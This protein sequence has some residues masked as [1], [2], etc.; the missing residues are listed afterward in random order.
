MRFPDADW[1]VA[2]AC[3]DGTADTLRLGE[4]V[5]DLY[6]ADSFTRA[7]GWDAQRGEQDAPAENKPRP[8]ALTEAQLAEYVGMYF[9]PEL[10]AIYRFAVEDGGPVVR[11]E[12]EPAL[13]LVTIATDRFELSFDDAAYW[14]PP[15]ASMAFQRDADGA[16]MGFS[17]SSWT[18]RGILFEKLQ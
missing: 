7:A 15:D 5:A 17:L 10:D 13:Q 18:E 1:S 12:Q 6:L 4:Q 8:A 14:D 9:S 16:I 3:N 11:I 2:I